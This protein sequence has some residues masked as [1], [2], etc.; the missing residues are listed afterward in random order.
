MKHINVWISSGLVFFF[1]TLDSLRVEIGEDIGLKYL[2][3]RVNLHMFLSLNLSLSL[4]YK[5]SC[6]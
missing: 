4:D 5:T 6:A 3:M 1:N 2:V